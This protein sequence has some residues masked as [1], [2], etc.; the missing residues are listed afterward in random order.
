MIGAAIRPIAICRRARFVAE[1]AFVTEVRS[2]ATVFAAY[3][4][5]RTNL[6]VVA[7]RPWRDRIHTPLNRIANGFVALV[8]FTAVHW[9]PRIGRTSVV[10]AVAQVVYRAPVA[11]VTELGA[12]GV[13]CASGVAVR[14]MS[15]K[16]VLTDR[17]CVEVVGVT[18]RYVAHLNLGG[19]CR[20]GLPRR[21]ELR[22]RYEKRSHCKCG[23]PELG[24]G[25]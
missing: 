17:D 16:G 23:E 1:T 2:G 4:E 21:I 24:P 18:R 14:K 15:R 22:I 5:L 8:A 6:T 20:S 25:K 11:V 7:H 13:A 3:V 9:T 12:Q 10:L 19:G